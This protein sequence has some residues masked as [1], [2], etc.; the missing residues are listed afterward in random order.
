MSIAFRAA[1][2]SDSSLESCRLRIPWRGP[3]AT[4]AQLAAPH[5]QKQG[6][7]MKE[8]EGLWGKP[9]SHGR[10]H[11]L[12][13]TGRGSW[14]PWDKAHRAWAA[15][16]LRPRRGKLCC[17]GTVSVYR[18]DTHTCTHTHAHKYAHTCTHRDCLAV[19]TLSHTSGTPL[20][21]AWAPLTSALIFSS[22]CGRWVHPQAVLRRSWG[23]TGNS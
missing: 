19:E 17:S 1:P 9:S 5:P 8:A 22:P 15:C 2:R 21:F 16:L 3:Q 20:L 18:A 23:P 4:K 10:K 6:A 14:S 7:N 12:P 13:W 11:P